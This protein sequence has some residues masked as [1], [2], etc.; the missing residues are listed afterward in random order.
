MPS[1]SKRNKRRSLLATS[2]DPPSDGSGTPAEQAYDDA[3]YESDQMPADIREADIRESDPQ[4]A[5]SSPPRLSAAEVAQLRAE[6]A[7]L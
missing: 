1:K 2:I 5:S 3:G 6:V 4:E 7:M